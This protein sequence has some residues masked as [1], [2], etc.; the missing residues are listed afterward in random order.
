MSDIYAVLNIFTHKLFGPFADEG[1]ALHYIRNEP[2][3]V[4]FTVL[5]MHTGKIVDSVS[6]QIDRIVEDFGPKGQKIQAIKEVRTVTGW[7]LKESK[8]AVDQRWD[9]FPF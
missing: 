6:S 4:G 7:G 8:D 3:S 1:E 9:K 2:S 5:P